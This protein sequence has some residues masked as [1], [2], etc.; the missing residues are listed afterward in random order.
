MYNTYD[1]EIPSG[2]QWILK[3][4]PFHFPRVA[5]PWGGVSYYHHLCFAYTEEHNLFTPV[6]VEG[7]P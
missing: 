2:C 6:D 4:V 1:V 7:W 5:K 3:K